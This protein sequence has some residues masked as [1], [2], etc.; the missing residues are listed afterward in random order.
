[1]GSETGVPGRMVSEVTDLTEDI[2]SSRAHGN[3][4]LHHRRT[5]HEL[6]D[7]FAEPG[8]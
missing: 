8:V 3:Q 1:M 6:A 2:R 4:R 7:F 5:A